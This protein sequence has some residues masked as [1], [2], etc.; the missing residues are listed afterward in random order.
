M[1]ITFSIFLLSA[2][3]SPPG[4]YY[5]T[6]YSSSR[7][8]RRQFPDDGL[9][10][11]GAAAAAVDRQALLFPAMD[12]VAELEE[13]EDPRRNRHPEGDEAEDQDRRE[14]RL[15]RDPEED[16]GADHP[17]VDRPHSGRC[18]RE[19][20]GDHAEEEALDDDRERDVDAEGVER[21]PE[22]A[23]A[24]GPEAGRAEHREA[25]ARGMGEEPEGEAEAFAEGG[26]DLA[27]GL[28]EVLRALAV[29]VAGQ[30]LL[31]VGGDQRDEDAEDHQQPGDGGGDDRQLD[32]A[33]A[34]HHPGPQQ[35]PE[36]DQSDG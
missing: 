2:I 32:R 4:V 6:L 12:G 21:G 17:G 29:G 35:D 36:E 5:F 18:Q 10:L 30:P 13:G 8:G 14:N 15:L 25:A 34:V 26:R 24:E 33:L 11:L 27:D 3:F 20:V 23:D 9:E 28:E 19:E 16:E 31:S 7:E 1:M 22:D